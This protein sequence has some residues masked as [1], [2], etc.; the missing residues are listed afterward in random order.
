MYKIA[1]CGTWF[2]LLLTLCHLK[3]SRHNQGSHFIDD[4]A[5]EDDDEDE[6]EEAPRKRRQRPRGLEFIDDSAAV[7]SDEEEEEEEEEAGICYLRS[8]LLFRKFP[9]DSRN[10]T[11]PLS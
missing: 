3:L 8:S 7:A 11:F 6:E 5:E 10:C 9:Y 2:L 1:I 4:V